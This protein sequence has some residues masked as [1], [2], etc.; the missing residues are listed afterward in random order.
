MKMKNL[1]PV[2]KGKLLPV[3]CTQMSIV[4]IE[5]MKIWY[6]IHNF[7]SVFLLKF[8]FFIV[9]NETWKM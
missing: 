4:S 5:W 1:V 3:V 9:S 8:G 7:S 2:S 6:I